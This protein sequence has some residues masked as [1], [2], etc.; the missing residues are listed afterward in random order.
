[1]RIENEYKELLKAL[2]DNDMTKREFSKRV[3][4]GMD[5]LRR[6]LDGSRKGSD[7]R[8]KRIYRE[9]GQLKGNYNVTPFEKVIKL[10]QK[11]AI[12]TAIYLNKDCITIMYK[13]DEQSHSLRLKAKKRIIL[14]GAKGRIILTDG[15]L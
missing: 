1:M 8:L 13:F 4:M 6:I 2:I 7:K 15:Q 9:W 10:I 11:E 3:G 5:G 12:I 14:H